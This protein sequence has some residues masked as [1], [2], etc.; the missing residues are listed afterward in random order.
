[1]VQYGQATSPKGQGFGQNGKQAGKF[2]MGMMD[3]N[4]RENDQE[5]NRRIDMG[6]LQ[7]LFS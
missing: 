6:E 5:A 1:V 3:E 4:N 2:N 7:S